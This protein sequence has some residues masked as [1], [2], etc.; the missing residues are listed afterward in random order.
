LQPVTAL[1]VDPEHLTY[2]VGNDEGLI[3]Y[4]D[5]GYFD[6]VYRGPSAQSPLISEEMKVVVDKVLVTADGTTVLIETF[7]SRQRGRCDK[8]FMLLSIIDMEKSKINAVA[9]KPLP[10][11]LRARIRFSLGFLAAD[12]AAAAK[13]RSSAQS[14]GLAPPSNNHLFAFL[15][16]E[17][18]VCTCLLGESQT[19]R[20]K[21]HYILPCE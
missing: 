5:T 16:K 15:D 3:T 2:A 4:F 13:R 12:F 17:F 1:A 10:A 21:R 8:E 7:Q 20:I 11:E 9:A 6:S 19:G 14:T 18:W